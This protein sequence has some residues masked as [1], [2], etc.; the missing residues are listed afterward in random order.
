MTEQKMEEWQCDLLHAAKY[1]EEHGWC[2]GTLLDINGSVCMVGAIYSVFDADLFSPDNRL[3]KD[4]E[5]FAR[6]ECAVNKLAVYLES[7]VPR[8][9][10]HFATSAEEVINIMKKCALKMTPQAD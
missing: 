10:D 4:R 7:P 1:I 3:K 5:L 8:Y 2:C 9:N 6:A